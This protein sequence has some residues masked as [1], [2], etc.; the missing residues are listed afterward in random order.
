M[1][2]KKVFK[3]FE[4]RPERRRRKEPRTDEW[5]ESIQGK[6]NQKC[7]GPGA[8]SGLMCGSHSEEAHMARAK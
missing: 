4:E 2:E 5:G 7:K 1:I 6:G 8:A 3:C